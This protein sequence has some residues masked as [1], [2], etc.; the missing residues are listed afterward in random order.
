V[1]LDDPHGRLLRDAG[2]VP[3][4]GYSLDQVSDL[5]VT[6][7]GSRFTWDG[8]AMAIALPGRFNV[9]NAVAAATVARELGV[10]TADIAAGLASVRSVPGRF[11]V[12]D[13]GQPFFAAVD[14]A[15]TPDGLEHLLEAAREIAAGGRVVLVFGAGGDRDPDKRPE[16]GAVAA[17]L[18]DVV[19]L[20]TDNPRHEDPAA[21]MAQV[22]HGMDH[23]RELLSEPDR[24]RAIAHAVGVARAGDVLVVAG[25]GHERH[26]IVGDDVI[27]FDDREVLREEL[28]HRMRAVHR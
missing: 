10:S 5:T 6:A 4:I 19:V 25:K 12:V 7:T 28:A 17:R 15:H 8:A 9:S 13:A 11:E 18:A 16:M 27:T 23:P 26:Q 20:T 2:Q 1:N 24:R 21:I 14:F 22:R 3:S